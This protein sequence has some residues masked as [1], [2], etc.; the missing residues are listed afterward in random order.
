MADVSLQLVREFFEL[1]VFRVL[2]N[3][4]QDPWRERSAEYS[5][6]LLVENVQPGPPRDVPFLLHPADLSAIERAVVHVRAWHTDRLYPSAMES[7]QL[8]NRLEADESDAIAQHVFDERP[9][10]TVLVISELPVARE[11]QERSATMLRR[12]GVDHIIEFPQLLRDMLERV[13]DHGNYMAS[14]TLQMLRLMKRYRLVRNQQ[15]EFSF[16]LEPPV[17]RGGPQVEAA[18]PPDAPD[19]T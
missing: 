18:P 8:L 9:F 2:T 19:E 10:V 5:P 16:P 6:Q 1:N 3:W 11:L 4:Q 17:P 12:A 13:S 14:P 7:S 15:L